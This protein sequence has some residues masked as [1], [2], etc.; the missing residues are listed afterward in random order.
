[1]L[2]SLVDPEED[3]V[4]VKVE[5]VVVV[6]EM[7]Q[8]EEM[9]QEVEMVQEDSEEDE[10]EAEMDREED[11]KVD[12]MVSKDKVTIAIVENVSKASIIRPKTTSCNAF[13]KRTPVSTSLKK[14]DEA[15]PVDLAAVLVM[16]VTDQVS[17]DTVVQEVQEDHEDQAVQVAPQA[18]KNSYWTLAR[19]MPMQ[20]TK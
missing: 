20:P 18:V 8:E 5:G 16:V 6:A 19:T 11:D 1:M 7:V 3:P 15:D 2:L 14:E 10:A 13:V 9:V 12:R 17:E 4:V